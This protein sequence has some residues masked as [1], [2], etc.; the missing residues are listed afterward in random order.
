MTY[1]WKMSF[2]DVDEVVANT[3]QQMGNIK[4]LANHKLKISEYPERTD[5]VP[6]VSAV[7]SEYNNKH[8][9]G[10]DKI[11]NKLKQ[12]ANCGMDIIEQTKQIELEVKNGVSSAHKITDN[13]SGKS[14]SYSFE[15]GDKATYDAFMGK[16]DKK[17]NLS[18]SSSSSSSNV[19][20]TTST[21]ALG[22]TAGVVSSAGSSSGLSVSTSSTSK[23]SDTSDK[24]STS[25]SSKEKTKKKKSTSSTKAKKNKNDTVTSASSTTNNTS[26]SK[27]TGITASQAV[28]ISLFEK[29]ILTGKSTIQDLVNYMRRVNIKESTIVDYLVNY[30][31]K[32][33]QQTT[34]TEV[35]PTPV[36]DSTPVPTPTPES[37]P[38]AVEDVSGDQFD[39]SFDTSITDEERDSHYFTNTGNV[40]SNVEPTPVTS[41]SSNTNYSA[42]TSSN[43]SNNNVSS[44]SNV[45]PAP[46]VSSSTDANDT[47]Q[48]VGETNQDS[49]QSIT[50]DIEENTTDLFDVEDDFDD[51]LTNSTTESNNKGGIPVVPI[52]GGVAAAAAAT[53]GAKIYKDRRDNSDFDLDEDRPSNDNKFWTEDEA[54]VVNSEEDNYLDDDGDSN[55]EEENVQDNEYHASQNNLDEDSWSMSDDNSDSESTF[56]LLGNNE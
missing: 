55:F 20:A 42:S 4:E 17:Y 3:N 1:E 18:A 13:S 21:S 24:S 47:S 22:I 36:P 41:T 38:S 15:L 2:E 8:S 48:V 56:D 53:V 46:S 32:L 9:E 12:L 7:F 33:K 34:S 11:V 5:S 27:S 49:S 16:L 43:Y 50:N 28:V 30:I 45:N 35:V 25:T 19:T 52:V 29:E 23:P 44:S 39:V 14:G 6:G 31:S 26:N 40:S 10:I 51:T 37:T 54:Q